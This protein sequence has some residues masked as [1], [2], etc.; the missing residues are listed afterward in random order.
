MDWIRRSPTLAAAPGV[1]R[2]LSRSQSRRLAHAAPSE[3]RVRGAPLPPRRALAPHGR[4]RRHQK[5]L[6]TSPKHSCEGMG[7]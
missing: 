6:L 4:H 7:D 1:A 3:P 5:R 2:R